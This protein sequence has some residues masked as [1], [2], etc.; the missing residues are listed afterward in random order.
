MTGRRFVGF[1]LLVAGVA[2]I[3]GW[4]PDHGAN[5]ATFLGIALAL[6]G[7]VLAD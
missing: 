1:C 3:L 5:G 7:I 2:V 4:G 6:G